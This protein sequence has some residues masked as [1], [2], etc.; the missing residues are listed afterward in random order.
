MN[1]AISNAQSG[2]GF[3]SDLAGLVFLSLDPGV[4]RPLDALWRWRASV[5]GAR[6]RPV[7]ERLAV[8]RTEAIGAWQDHARR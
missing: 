5:G 8:G 6:M 2:E 1:W 7:M 4:V 3:S